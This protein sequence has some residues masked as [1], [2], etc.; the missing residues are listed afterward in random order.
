MIK[1]IGSVVKNVL[2]QET[3]LCIPDLKYNT[4]QYVVWVHIKIGSKRAKN[5]KE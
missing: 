2:V 1:G 4:F 3:T 5:S